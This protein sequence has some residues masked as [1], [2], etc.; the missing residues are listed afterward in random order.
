MKTF[1]S[2]PCLFRPSAYEPKN[3]ESLEQRTVTGHPSPAS[4]PLPRQPPTRPPPL[5]HPP[6]R[7]PHPCQMNSKRVL[8]SSSRQVQTRGRSGPRCG[9]RVAS[10][11][12]SSSGWRRQCRQCRTR[13]ERQ[14]FVVFC[15]LFF[16]FDIFS[17]RYIS[18]SNDWDGNRSSALINNVPICL[19]SITLRPCSSMNGNG[20]HS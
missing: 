7:P 17:R 2:L 19:T 18:V 12:R 4:T 3:L 10:L 13:P 1:S 20:L 9:V 6:P 8:I 14:L 15:L 11:C 16:V 5:L